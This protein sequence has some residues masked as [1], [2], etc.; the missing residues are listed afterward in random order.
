MD[1]LAE[2]NRMTSELTVAEASRRQVNMIAEWNQH[3]VACAAA[4]RAAGAPANRTRPGADSLTYNSW[5]DN[6][7]AIVDAFREEAG[8][9][10]ALAWERDF[11]AARAEAAAADHEAAAATAAVT[12]LA[13]IAA[14]ELAAAATARGEAARLREAARAASEWSTSAAFC[15][16][17]GETIRSLEHTITHH[18]RTALTRVGGPAEAGTDPAHHQ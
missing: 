1:I 18:V 7:Q 13:I 16:T 4:A 2:F 6:A 10:E 3:A 8:L 12:G 9:G 11:E 14:E 5:R 15:A 17:F